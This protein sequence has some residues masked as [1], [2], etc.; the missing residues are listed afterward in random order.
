MERYGTSASVPVPACWCSTR[1][2]PTA[3]CAGP[4]P[5]D[6]LPM[7]HDFALTAR[8]LVFL[9]PPLVYDARRKAAGASFLDA[10]VWRPELGMRALV[11]DK[12]DW[13][14]Q[15]TFALPAGFLFHIGNAWEEPTAQGTAIH[16]DYLRS[17]DASGVFGSTREV[18]RARLVPDVAPRLTVASLDLSTGQAT[19]REWPVEAEFPRIDPRLVGQRHRHVVH[20]TQ[21]RGGLPFW[22]AVART[23]VESGASQRF[24]YGAQVLVEEHVFV[25]DGQ[26]PGWVLGTA[27]DCA[28]RKTVLSCF[29]AD[30]LADGPV[31]QATLPYALPLGLHG[32]FVA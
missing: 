29:V 3:R 2:R 28:R 4:F 13:K 11:V 7:V 8:Y 22:S 14:R 31:A 9:L 15:R 26:G 10:H 18:M 20:A 24:S 30:A 1:S 16:V 21:P 6:N 12:A 25:P 5:V 27:L 23:D 17:P 19:Q 32:T